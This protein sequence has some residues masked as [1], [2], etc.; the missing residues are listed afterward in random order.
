MALQ[1]LLLKNASVPVGSNQMQCCVE[2]VTVRR[3]AQQ[4]EQPPLSA[5][6]EP[7]KG[8]HQPAR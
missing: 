6:S 7:V 1:G 2:A 8:R 4:V 5:H 3:L